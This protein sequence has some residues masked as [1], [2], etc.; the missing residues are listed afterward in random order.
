MTGIVLIG[1][2]SQR[3][4]S[5]KVVSPVG[6]KLLVEHVIDVIAPLFDEILLVGHPREP[7][8]GHKI[9]ED[10][11]P[12]SGPIG[13]IF[14][15]LT[16]ARSPQCFVFAADMPNLN[17]AFI[18]H[19]ITLVEEYDIVVPVW[20]KGREPLHAIYHH[21]LTGTIEHLLRRGERKIYPLIKEANTRML[22]EE[23]IRTF[24]R[25]EE[26]F[27]NINTQHD[28]PGAAPR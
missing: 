27:S 10:L 6:E 2:K 5:D 13:G 3:F 21:R 14:T 18:S 12:G 26:I 16:H 22:D 11:I 9:V 23:T 24:G 4:G 1:G 7:L 17:Q 20:S 28:L 15:A 25:P 8:L 19:M